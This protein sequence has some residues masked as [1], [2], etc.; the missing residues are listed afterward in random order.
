VY[1][2]QVVN[3]VITPS[4]QNLLMIDATNDVTLVF[5]FGASLGG[6]GGVA[7]YGI[8][9]EEDA[10]WPAINSFVSFSEVTPPPPPAWT[11]LGSGL[12]GTAGV[13]ALAGTGSLEA[14]SPGSLALTAAKPSSVAMLFVSLS[15]SPVSFKGGTLLAVPQLLL[16][17][18]STG[19]S[20]ALALGFTW[21][22]GVP[23]ATALWFQY[24]I[25]D[26]AAVGGVAL[27]N[28]LKALTP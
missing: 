16:V 15:S 25:E 3:H 18:L 1:G 24:A 20:G 13:P 11:D 19:A 10:L 6:E 17:P 2:F 27:S 21:P 9:A 22:P 26:A 8:Q 23:A 14:G 4:A 5:D 7:T 12:A 28:G